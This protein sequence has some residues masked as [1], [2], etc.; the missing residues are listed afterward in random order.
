[1][2]P[3]PPTFRIGQDTIAFPQG[4]KILTPAKEFAAIGYW[5]TS[6]AGTAPVENGVTV[7]LPKNPYTALKGSA[8]D[9]YTGGVQKHGDIAAGLTNNAFLAFRNV[10]FGAGARRV[11]VE[12][13]TAAAGGTVEVWLDHISKDFF[14][15]NYGKCVGVLT[16]PSTRGS[17]KYKTISASLNP[18]IIKKHHLY[19]VYKNAAGGSINIESV[20]FS[21]GKVPDVQH[22][23]ARLSRTCTTTESLML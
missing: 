8:A 15:Q 1:M 14:G 2:S 19:L 13:S 3:N 22:P 17:G 6:P 20:K 16:V 9:K 12:L 10:Y 4:S 5:V 21:A 7:K 23:A 18:G 11:S